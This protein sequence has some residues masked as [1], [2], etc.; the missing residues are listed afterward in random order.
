MDI[1]N[2]KWMDGTGQCLSVTIDGTHCAVPSDMG[3]K[4]YRAILAWA[5]IDGNVIADP[6]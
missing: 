4:E 3:N 5:E 2:P 6:D 1:E